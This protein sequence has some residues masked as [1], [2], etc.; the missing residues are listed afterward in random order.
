MGAIYLQPQGTV[1]QIQ[2]L[3]VAVGPAKPILLQAA[4]SA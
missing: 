4:W 2:Q 3:F 1:G